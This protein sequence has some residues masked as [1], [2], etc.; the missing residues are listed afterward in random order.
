MSNTEADSRAPRL[1]L[2]DDEPNHLELINKLLGLEFDSTGVS[3]EI[4]TAKN[5]AEALLVLS[6]DNEET[7]PGGVVVDGL[8]GD[9]W[10]VLKF[11][12]GVGCLAILWSNNDDLLDRARAE[13]TPALLKTRG[14]KPLLDLIVET[15]PFA[16]PAI[17]E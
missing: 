3:I 2:V 6:G 14:M 9:C 5:V 15:F 10:E 12:R 8:E 11:A 4:I 16:R 13:N 17:V 7:K 1:L